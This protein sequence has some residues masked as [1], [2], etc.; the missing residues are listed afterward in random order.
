MSEHFWNGVL[1]SRY[2]API[3]KHLAAQS[4]EGGVWETRR[5]FPFPFLASTAWQ[6]PSRLLY[7]FR[8]N[9][10]SAPCAALSP[11]FKRQ[12]IRYAVIYETVYESLFFGL[13]G[14]PKG[15]KLWQFQTTARASWRSGRLRPSCWKCNFFSMKSPQPMA[16][17]WKLLPFWKDFFTMEQLTK[18]ILPICFWDDNIL[19]RYAGILSP[20][21]GC[22]ILTFSISLRKSCKLML[23]GN[24]NENFVA[25][26]LCCEVPAPWAS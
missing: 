6:L 4:V 17:R 19:I 23:L 18:V 8:R 9:S 25:Y 22:R 26:F 12:G 2:T 21:L 3:N 24:K 7:G 16:L 10:R 13:L 15:V 11:V 5:E 20:S 1:T 14:N